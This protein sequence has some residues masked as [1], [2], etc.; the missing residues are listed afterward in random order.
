MGKKTG[1]AIRQAR[2]S[3]SLTREQLAGKIPG[4]TA[5]MLTQA[6][7]G[8][9]EL[10]QTMCKAIAKAT[11]VTQATLLNAEKA[12]PEESG[13]LKLT[14]AEK[15]LILRYRSAD[16]GTQKAVNALLNQKPNEMQ[17]LVHTFFGKR[18]KQIL[19]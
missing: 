9:L 18:K 8:Q 15:K 1:A 7:R 6:E 17:Q 16:S 12:A 4:L 3:A 10:T 19:K 14:A 11:G 13:E 2:R 5:Q